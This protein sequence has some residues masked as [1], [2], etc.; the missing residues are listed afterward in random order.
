MI[1]TQTLSETY[2]QSNKLNIDKR[3]F[4]ILPTSAEAILWLICFWSKANC[5]GHWLSVV[6]CSECCADFKVRSSSSHFFENFIQKKK[7]T[8]EENIEKMIFWNFLSK[9]VAR[10]F[11][12]EEKICVNIIYY[13]GE[14]HCSDKY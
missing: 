1:F 14:H 5:S 7:K 13:E 12:R 10:I 4:R 3:S 2:N 11:E 8:E 9:W 6:G